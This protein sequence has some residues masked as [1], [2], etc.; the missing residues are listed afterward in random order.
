MSLGGFDEYPFH[1]HPAPFSA[2][3]TTDAHYNDGYWFACYDS[4][5]YVVAG[6]RLHPNS[7]VIDGFAGVVHRGRQHC[8]R[9]SRALRPDHDRLAVGPL[10]LEIVEPL[11]RLRVIVGQ[12]P[13]GIELELG[14]E[15]RCSP[16]TEARHRHARYGVVINDTLRYTQVCRASG[17]ISLGGERIEADRWHAIRD[18]S[19]GVRSSMAPPDR[20]GGFE[21]PPEERSRRA[22]RLWVPFEVEGHCGFFQTHEDRDGE[23]IDFEGWLYY[24]DGRQIALHSVT[25]AL[26]YEPGTRRPASGTLRLTDD[27]GIERDYRL[28]STGLAA[29]VQGLG[30]YGGWRDGNS[31]GVYRGP[32][33][34][35]HDVYSSNPAEEPTGPSHVPLERRLGPTEHPCLITGPD[36]AEGMA[37]LEHS[38]FGAYT[39]YLFS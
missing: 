30:Y 1:Q 12:N 19:W 14:F 8:L 16:F 5:W 13:S 11:R 36:G 23:A 21:R 38:V 2:P 4:E 39:P 34:V 29:D 35:E 18:H 20:F 24:D 27:A 17:S 37:H 31:A 32:E 10:Q 33:L 22:F 26:E 9:A 3:A 7:N 15:S 28:R 6:L 25:H